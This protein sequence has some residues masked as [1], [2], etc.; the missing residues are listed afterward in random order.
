M[1][2]TGRQLAHT[3]YA[4]QSAVTD[5][6]E[7][8]RCLEHLPREIDALQHVARGLV[9]HYR[10]DD[11]GSHG[12][13]EERLSEIDSRYAGTMLERLV[14]LDGRPLTE[15]R[16]PQ[17]RL[18]GCCRDFTVLFLTMARH[19]GIPTRAR[20]GFAT[21]FVPG[22]NV[23]HEVAEVWDGDAARWRLVDPELGDNHIDPNDGARVNPL[24]VPRDRFVVAGT[25]WQACRRGEADP[26]TFVVDPGLEIEQT[27][28]WPY[29][30]HNVIHDLAA[31]NKVEMILWDEWGLMEERQPS[32]NDLQ[33]LDL[34]AEVTQTGDSDEARR[35][36]QV[37]PG[38]RVPTVVTTYSMASGGVP[39]KISLE[40]G[41]RD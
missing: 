18:L 35:V 37:E 14:E 6:G 34:V 17:A 7:M 15:E 11:P 26:E 21:Y 31:L 10:A 9:L 29:L 25:A 1:T 30:R 8:T 32:E 28:G 27:R 16:P 41:S 2:E 5:P 4:D 40:L 12:I 33:L 20:V 22:F 38:L 24:D 13:P 23:D 36:Y 3:Y 19:L 39:R